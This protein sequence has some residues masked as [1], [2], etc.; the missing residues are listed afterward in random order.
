MHSFENK[1]RPL[2]ETPNTNGLRQTCDKNTDKLEIIGGNRWTITRKE[3]RRRELAAAR[4][5]GCNNGGTMNGTTN[6]SNTLL[7]P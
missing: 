2:K 7:T 4:H 5:W 6:E 1:Q 3:E